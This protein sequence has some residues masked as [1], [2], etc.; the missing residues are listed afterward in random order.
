KQLVDGQANSLSSQI[1]KSNLNARKGRREL[2]T[3][4]SGEDTRRADALPNGLNVQ[5]I[6][7]DQHPAPAL[8]QRSRSHSRIGG[9]TLSVDSL[10]GVDSDVRLGAMDIDLG[11]ADIG[12]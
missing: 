10:V 3:L 1:P 7:S 2:P 5:R 6:L 11:C 4:G 12:D 8:N 9:F